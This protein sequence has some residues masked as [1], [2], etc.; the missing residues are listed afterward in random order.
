[1]N[2]NLTWTSETFYTHLQNKSQL[3]IVQPSNQSK[4]YV[5]KDDF[6]IVWVNILFFEFTDVN[7]KLSF[8]RFSCKL[9]EDKTTEFQSQ[10][11]VSM[12]VTYSNTRLNFAFCLMW[13]ANSQ[14]QSLC[15]NHMCTWWDC[16]NGVKTSRCSLAQVYA[17]LI[18]C[19]TCFW[20][21]NARLHVNN[22]ALNSV[23]CWTWLWLFHHGHSSPSTS[24]H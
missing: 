14:M 22:E 20:H 2:S 15:L 18:T 9:N 1:M 8:F 16:V 24:L 3:S 21:P 23:Q 6:I 13:A 17:E 11:Y 4:S 10:F 12:T 19:Y 7:P 5:N